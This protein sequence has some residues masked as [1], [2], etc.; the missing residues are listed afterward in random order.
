MNL[1]TRLNSNSYFMEFSIYGIRS[2]TDSDSFASSSPICMPF[3]SVSCLIAMARNPS[4]MLSKSGK[5]GHPGFVPD[6]GEKGEQCSLGLKVL[7]LTFL[8]IVR[9]KDT[10]ENMRKIW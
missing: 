8:Y 4:M 9:K 5:S 1:P 10:S 7:N 2:S 3:I 6:L